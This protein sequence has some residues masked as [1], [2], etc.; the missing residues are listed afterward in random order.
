MPPW[1]FFDHS[2]TVAIMAKIQMQSLP[3]EV[4]YD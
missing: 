2:K 4:F 1:P 3:H